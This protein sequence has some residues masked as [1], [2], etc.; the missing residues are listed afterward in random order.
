MMTMIMTMIMTKMMIG[1]RVNS[2]SFFLLYFFSFKTY[3]LKDQTGHSPEPYNIIENLQFTISQHGGKS[4]LYKQLKEM[5]N[6]ENKIYEGYNDQ[7]N[8]AQNE[9]EVSELRHEKYVFIKE[10]AQKLYDFL[11][12]NI[13]QLTAK[14]CTAFD[15]VPYRVWSSLSEK[16]TIIIDQIKNAR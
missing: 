8:N 12:A 1:E 10:Y 14:D 6:T 2:L 16:Y 11:W 9:E 15:M 4:M 7:I 3:V 5:I 13:E